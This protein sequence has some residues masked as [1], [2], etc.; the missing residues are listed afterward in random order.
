[1]AAKHPGLYEGVDLLLVSAASAHFISPLVNYHALI[2]LVLAA[3]GWVA[4]WI[5]VRLTRSYGWA[6]LAVVLVTLNMSNDLR[7]SEHLHLFRY[8][9]ILLTVYA[10]SRYLDSPSLARG[11]GLGLA[12]GLIL[13][14]SFYLAF[15]LMVGLGLWWVGCLI[16]GRLQRPHYAAAGAATLAFAVVG[17]GLTFPLWLGYNRGNPGAEEYARRPAEDVWVYGSDFWQYLVSP[18]WQ[19]HGKELADYLVQMTPYNRSD[20]VATLLINNQP[21]DPDRPP[22]PLALEPHEGW[23]YPGIIVLLAITVY[24]LARLCGWRLCPADPQFLD[25]LL[26]LSAIMVVLS[27]RAGPSVLLYALAPAFRCYG[28]AGLIA[29][30]LWSVATPL[31]LCGLARRLRRLVLRHVLLVGALA[32]ALYEGSQFTDRLFFARDKGGQ[33]VP[34]WV[35]W[36]AVQPPH[37]R[38]VVLPVAGATWHGDFS[39][40]DW[41][42]L[43]YRTLHRHA[44][45]NGGEMRVLWVE[46]ER[47]GIS[48][49]GMKPQGLRYLASLGYD[50]LA[51]SKDFGQDNPW[52]ATS[53]ALEEA[54]ALGD[55]HIYR[56]RRGS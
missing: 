6:A 43:Y 1:M 40:D 14:S 2:I 22:I 28:R 8:G 33:A 3:N 7:V 37:V 21:V 11:L 56:I 49:K 38:M 48:W 16:G 41:H 30:A 25:R 29:V 27:L 18:R 55:W 19:Y 10:F 12:A 35:D 9:W 32:L 53:P 39:W 34:A 52:M 20:E 17:G 45:L 54:A 36:L 31:V 23:N 15:F 13:A 51:V 26:G 44:T 4:A 5:V 47:H 42:F 50:T 46:L 24:G